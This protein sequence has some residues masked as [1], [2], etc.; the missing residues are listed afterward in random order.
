MRIGL[1]LN[2]VGRLLAS[3]ANVSIPPLEEQFPDDGALEDTPEWEIPPSDP[4][5]PE[6]GD[7]YV[8]PAGHAVAQARLI[9][10]GVA[11][12]NENAGP[13]NRHVKVKLEEV[14]QSQGYV[15]A[16]LKDS[17]NWIG[18]TYDVAEG[19]LKLK[20]ILDGVASAVGEAAVE[21]A[22]GDYI[23]AAV[24]DGQ[25]WI[26]HNGFAVSDPFAVPTEL[27]QLRTGLIAQGPATSA[28][29][30]EFNFEEISAEPE[31]AV[32]AEPAAILLGFDG[33]DGST[34]VPDESGYDL[35][36][37]IAS[38]AQ[39]DTAQSK[40]GGSAVLFDGADD[41]VTIPWVPSLKLGSND[42]TIEFWVRPGAGG[43]TTQHMAGQRVT[44]SGANTLNWCFTLLSDKRVEFFL[45]NSALTTNSITSAGALSTAGTWYHLAACR[46]GNTLRLFIDGTQIGSNVD[47]SSNPNVYDYR[48]PITLGC[49]GD[50]QNDFSGWMDEF[51]FLPGVA[52]YTAA[53]TPP[54]APFERPDIV[55]PPSGADPQW[56]NTK[57][58]ASFNGA[59]GAT[60]YTEESTNARSATFTGAS[61]SLSNSIKP[62]H[63]Q[64]CGLRVSSGRL[65]F[66]DSADWAFGSGAFTVEAYVYFASLPTG[67]IVGQRASTGGSVGWCMTSVGGNLECFVNNGTTTTG[68][69]GAG[70]IAGTWQHICLERGAGG[71]LRAYVQGQ[72][73][74]SNASPVNVQD[75]AVALSIGACANGDLQSNFTMQ[76]LR[77]TKGVARY[78]SDSGFDPPY[79]GLLDGS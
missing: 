29:I 78:D 74:A 27:E 6:P 39:I 76:D 66:A 8:P 17:E 14:T 68:I 15:A 71:K 65:T 72:M 25:I 33:V 21:L 50:N 44:A 42:F 11:Y 47:L 41:K 16:L 51:R 54:A 26:M 46:S 43:G 53:F 63:S 67:H 55:E 22:A 35:P 36:V 9:T 70:L 5:P 32:T 12:R 52:L 69:S 61:C 58:L 30:S 49:M 62:M 56:A 75:A 23:G 60:S 7:L 77:I 31:P 18:T 19:K 48:Y 4:N 13:Q 24:F 79:R 10:N 1:G 57:L 28:W 2:L 45:K 59:N 34:T 64:T 73:V 40:F 38:N 37:F 20:Q 3:T